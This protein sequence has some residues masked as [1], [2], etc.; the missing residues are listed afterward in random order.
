MTGAFSE[1]RFYSPI[2][3]AEAIRISMVNARNAEFFMIIKAD[4]GRRYREK[5]DEA[6]S[7]IEEAIEAGL[8][9]GQVLPA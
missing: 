7:M 3:D 5:R 8:E 6:L 2:L 9:P 1:F 4:D